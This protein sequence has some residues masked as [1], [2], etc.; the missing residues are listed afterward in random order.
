MQLPQKNN[1]R[2]SII[3]RGYDRPQ[4][5][6]WANYAVR[7]SGL[8]FFRSLMIHLQAINKFVFLVSS[9]DN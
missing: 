8:I 9:V 1:N 7:L 2:G 5:N 3:P 6:Q 4:M